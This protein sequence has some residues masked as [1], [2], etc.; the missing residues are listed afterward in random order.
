[1]S[2]ECPITISSW[3]LGDK[4]SFEDRVRVSKNAGYE[5]IGLRVE[6]YVDALDSG[7]TDRDMLSILDKYQ[8]PVTEVENIEHW[9]EEQ[10]SY[11]QKYKEQL[12]FHMARLFNVQHINVMLMEK[13]SLDRV[14]FALK[15]LCKRAGDK[16]IALEPMPYGAVTDLSSGLEVIEKSGAKN[17]GLIL[18][19]WHWVRAHE[20]YSLLTE[21]S[22]E[23]IIS[24]QINDARQHSH[25]HEELRKESLHDRVAP[26]QGSH[27]TGKFLTML[28]KSNV[29][30]K[31]IGV[32]VNSDRYLSQGLDFTAQ[33]TYDTSKE[34]LLKYWPALVM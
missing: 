22:A 4:C 3:T 23:K 20:P 6:N 1:M 11:E 9:A 27:E 26:N 34:V 8:I 15:E 30:P 29:K 32:E 24:I 14:A 25:S 13:H 17:V 33:Y 7:L 21:D 19:H 5:G 18:D 28:K 10:R 2:K 12:C 16:I 31:I